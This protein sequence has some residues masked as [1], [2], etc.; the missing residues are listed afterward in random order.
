LGC[1]PYTSSP[2]EYI[3]LVKTSDGS[4]FKMKQ[5]SSLFTSTDTLFS[6]IL[7][8]GESYLSILGIQSNQDHSMNGIFSNED[9][10]ALL[11]MRAD[12][13]LKDSNCFRDL[14]YTLISV[15]NVLVKVS[16]Y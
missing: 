14:T 4:I 12:I 16:S 13:G 7:V 15:A 2:N 8:D 9:R 11:T 10:Q 5:L 1:N 3:A 6:K